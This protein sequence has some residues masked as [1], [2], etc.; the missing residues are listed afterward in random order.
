M[1]RYRV[2]LTPDASSFGILDRDSY[3]YCGLPDK[4]GEVRELHFTARPAAE[5]WLASCYRL[6]QSW[7]GN[8]EG[9]PPK[10]WRPLPPDV[11]PFA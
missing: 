11:S 5:A 8:G 4:S 6:W 9:R 7:E 1:D 3:G 2:A 10:K